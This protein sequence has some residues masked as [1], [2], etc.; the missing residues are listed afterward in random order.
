MTDG[1]LDDDFRYVR[2]NR[3]SL[4]F[5][6][7]GGMPWSLGDMITVALRTP[8]ALYGIVVLLS[9]DLAFIDDLLLGATAVIRYGAWHGTGY[10]V[11]PPASLKHTER[12]DV[13]SRTD[14]MMLMYVCS[15][16]GMLMT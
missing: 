2:L 7:V 3:E 4:C 5:V 16:T 13:T 15:P 1:R 12:S 14:W 6:L 11:F 8:T 9:D 10:A